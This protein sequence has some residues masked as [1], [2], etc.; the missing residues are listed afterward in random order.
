MA[1]CILVFDQEEKTLQLWKNLQQASPKIN[2]F[3]II[4]PNS[5]NQ[6]DSNNEKSTPNNES[7]KK[8]KIHEIALFN[9]KISR[10]ERQRKMSRWLMPFGFISGLTFAGMTDLSTFS[11]FGFGTTSE[12]IF[13]GILGMIAG[14]IGSFFA[15]R[16]IN[17][18]KDDLKSILKRNEEG[19]WLVLLETSLESQ[20]PWPSINEIQPLEVI[21]LNPN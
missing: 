14:W 6:P 15:A 21:N 9:P 1:I 7:P 4:E 5:Q 12:P 3:Q 17:N 10:K 8:L 13:G 11:S 16:S 18:N 20:L 2:K 19:L